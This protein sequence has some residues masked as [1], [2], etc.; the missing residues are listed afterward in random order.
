MQ[1]EISEWENNYEKMI[2]DNDDKILMVKKLN[3]EWK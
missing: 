3:D 2:K 1:E